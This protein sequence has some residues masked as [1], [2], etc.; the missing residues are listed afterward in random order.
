MSG[1]IVA[2]PNRSQDRAAGAVS[3]TESKQHYN[4]TLTYT[5]ASNTSTSPYLSDTC[6]P[7][8]SKHTCAVA[9][10][11]AKL[12]SAHILLMNVRLGHAAYCFASWNSRTPWC[13]SVRVQDPCHGN[14]STT[15]HVRAAAVKEYF[16]YLNSI[17]HNSIVQGT[18][19]AHQSVSSAC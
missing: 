3:A 13:L 9:E 4:L 10:P 12:I 6:E 2:Q 15:R 17:F 18:Y 5:A 11:G 19:Q 14:P 8:T 16:Q 1:A 7:R